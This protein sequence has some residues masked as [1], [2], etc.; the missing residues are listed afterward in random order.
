MGVAQESRGPF[1][2]AEVIQALKGDVPAKRIATLARQYGISFQLTPE[3]ED[4]LRKAGA[5][6]ELLEALRP[7]APPPPPPTVAG[8]LL[9]KSTPAGAQVFFDGTLEGTTDAE[10][11]LELL[12]LPPGEHKMRLTLAGYEDY[13]QTINLLAG[14]PA[15]FPATLKK[16]AAPVARFRV[17]LEHKGS[18]ELI[19]GNGRLQFRADHDGGASFE[20]PL[21]E[22]TYGP[23]LKRSLTAPH[24]TL[25]GFYLRSGDGKDRVFHSDSTH[26]ILQLLQQS[27]SR[28][29]H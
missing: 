6:D 13:E 27:G 19:I 14:Q 9:I 23:F 20:S 15:S 18:G 22:I 2:E 29:P 3:T 7:L 25:D 16:S 17:T 8:R 21:R 24:G 26:A 1:S 28:S 12:K 10:G 4:R 5:T 11:E